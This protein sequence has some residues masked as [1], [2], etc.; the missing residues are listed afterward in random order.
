MTRLRV[1]YLTSVFDCAEKF[2][3]FSLPPI[4]ARGDN[5]IR[6]AGSDEPTIFQIICLR[7]ERKRAIKTAT[8]SLNERLAL[9]AMVQ[10]FDVWSQDML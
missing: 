8:P 5:L 4:E 6:S 10:F 3:C 9:P 1:E 2:L 7:A